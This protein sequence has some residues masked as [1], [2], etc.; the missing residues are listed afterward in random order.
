MLI[1]RKFGSCVG[2]AKQLLVLW[3][4]SDPKSRTNYC[5]PYGPT[6]HCG[7]PLSCRPQA[8]LEGRR[9]ISGYVERS[10]KTVFAWSA[11]KY[12]ALRGLSI[13]AYLPLNLVPLL[14]ALRCLRACIGEAELHWALAKTSR[15]TRVVPSSQAAASHPQSNWCSFGGMAIS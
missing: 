12:S 11:A 5:F 15:N 10:E 6:Q 3:V 4:R 7:F 2:S 8:V 9:C 14:C 13:H 1:S